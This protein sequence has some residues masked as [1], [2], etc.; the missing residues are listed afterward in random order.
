MKTEVIM[1]R[2]MLGV[3][4]RQKHKTGFFSL[5]DLERVGNSYRMQNNKPIQKAT[6]YFRSPVSKE[7]IAELK[8]EVGVV[9]TGGKGRGHEKWVHPYLFIDIALWYSPTLKVNVYRWI[10]DNLTIFRDNGGESFKR[11]VES[12]GNNCNIR[13][14]FGVA[15]P[16]IAKKIYT[17]VGVS[18]VNKW[19]KATEE[20]LRHRDEIQTAITTASYF[21]NDYSEAVD[22]GIEIATKAI[23]KERK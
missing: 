21:V 7:F 9:Q 18:G 4:V 20:Q 16:T 19:E 17:A 5:S 3:T 15:L 6:E 14:K 2:E 13:G 8:K 1:E 12:L 23:Q 10:Y 22:R 11:M